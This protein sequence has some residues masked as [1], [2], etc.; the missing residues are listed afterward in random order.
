MANSSKGSVMCSAVPN[1][2][3]PLKTHK[4]CKAKSMPYRD[5]PAA[6]ANSLDANVAHHGI[7]QQ[8]PLSL[9]A[10][11]HGSAKDWTSSTTMLAL[12][13]ANLAGRRYNQDA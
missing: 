10:A 12:P 4:I 9:W 5:Q 3:N 8:T 6:Y 11:L 2:N 7:L 1:T 13:A